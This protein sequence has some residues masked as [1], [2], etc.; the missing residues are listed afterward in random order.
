MIIQLCGL[1]GAGKSTLARTVETML[2]RKSYAVEVIDGD[3][4]RKTLCYGL[5]FSKND[6]LEN[7]R[8]M[9]FVAGQLSKHGIIAIICAI[10]PYEEMR[11]E[12]TAT[13]P[14]TKL[15]HVD[16]SIETLKIRDTKG[17]YRKAFLPSGHPE[18]IQNL[19]GINDHFDI[20]ADPDL[21]VNTDVQ[22]I[23][24]CAGVIARFIQEQN[25][26]KTKWIPAPYYDL[27]MIKKI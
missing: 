5:S 10:N 1:S 3:E 26:V 24:D 25:T 21:Y 27:R 14:H 23:D 22:T 16:C 18:K 19:T 6:R 4:Y 15:I 9:A 11:K 8:R 17:L 20:P 12:V 2:K 7:M 13:Y